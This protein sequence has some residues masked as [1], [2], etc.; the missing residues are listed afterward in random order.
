MNEE[1]LDQKT[2]SGWVPKPIFKDNKKLK[3]PLSNKFDQNQCKLGYKPMLQSMIMYR[4][5][6]YSGLSNK[7]ARWNKMCRLENWAKFKSF[8]NLNLRW[9]D[10]N[11][12]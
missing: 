2:S 1:L 6:S 12:F 8:E 3:S 5:I 7:R 10:P 11:H 9:L 4:I